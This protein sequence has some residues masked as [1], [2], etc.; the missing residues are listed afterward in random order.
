MDIFEFELRR[1]AYNGLSQKFNLGLKEEEII[2][3]VKKRPIKIQGKLQD[4]SPDQLKKKTLETYS[5]QKKS[6][7]KKS[8][9]QKIGKFSLADYINRLEYELFVI[10]KMGY[11]TYFLI[12]Q[13][14]INRAKKNKIAVGTGRWSAAGSLLSYLIWITDVDPMPY[15]LLF[16]R[17]L[18]PARV[19]MPD[20]DTDFEDELRDRVIDYV[21]EKYGEQKV[22][23]IGTYMKLAPR[24][25]FKDV[26]RIK[27]IKF[28]MANKISAMIEG[29]TLQQSVEE[30]PSLQE[31][32]EADP[33][34]K[35]IIDLASQLEWNIRQVWVHACWVIIS[36]KP[37]I[38]YTP[39]QYPPKGNKKE[40]VT[41]YDGH[42]LED[43]W[44]LKMDFLGLRNLSIIKN[45][46]K[47]IRAK[48]KE[49]NKQLPKLI[50]EFFDTMNFHPPLEDKKTFEIFQKWDTSGV[51][52]FESDWMKNWLKQLKPTNIDDIIAMVALYRP[53]PMAFIPSYID[54]KHW[55][56]KISYMSE[57]LKEILS[58][59]YSPEE[60][61]QEEKKLT[62]DLS[63]FMDITYWIPVYQEQLMRLVQAMAGFSLAEADLLRRWVGKKIKELIEKIKKDFV[64]KAQEYRNYKPETAD[65]IYEKMIMPAARYSF[66]K[67]HAA[68]YAL[69]AY[70]TAYLKA[71]Y[72]LEFHAALLRS[73][74][75]DT[76][77]LA[78]FINEL[79]IKWFNITPPSVNKSFAHMAAVWD[80]IV[81]WLNAIK[82]L[83]IEVANAIE[84]ERVKNWPYKSL[85]D[86][87]KRNKKIINK[88]LLEALTYSWALDEFVDRNLILKNLE[89]IL[90]WIK[91]INANEWSIG[92]F[93]AIDDH[94]LVLK[95]QNKITKEEKLLQEFNSFKTFVSSHPF[96]GLYKFLKWK[97][98]PI[99]TLY[100]EK[101]KGKVEIIGLVKEITP[102]R[103][104]GFFLTLEDVSWEIDIYLPDR[105]NINKFDV[106]VVK[107]T[108][109]TRLRPSQIIKIDLEEMI[110]Y[111]KK[112][113]KYDEKLK[114]SKV[115]K[116][117][118]NWT[119]SSKSQ[120][121]PIT[122]ISAPTNL[123]FKLPSDIE[124]LKQIKYITQTLQGDIEIKIEGIPFKVSPQGLKAIQDLLANK[125][126]N[127]TNNQSIV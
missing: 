73:V 10:H 24:A 17:F 92:L 68:C 45:T 74:E 26:A 75:E 95:P 80:Q 16:E 22:A 96:D 70:Q 34:I 49:E 64:K 102:F 90:N 2:N 87:L 9:G 38:N 20:I 14:Y 37:A 12:V 18:N 54:R 39:L 91:V 97:F 19:S 21:R 83:G 57:E 13:D 82:G 1:L 126:T 65:Y 3:L 93:G 120:S 76:D 100:D 84:E 110:N 113:G 62:E 41:Q 11:D 108:K 116:E 55:K 50:Q 60:V 72:P 104:K 115:R 40:Y 114:V 58:K 52:Q 117:R 69:I 35:E 66:N 15:D 4:L 23:R 42:V 99:S 30:S 6:F 47:I 46:L 59:K 53:G 112:A 56:E 123:E 8:E 61:I 5:D 119:S 32:I 105:L 107:W 86:F 7:I 101:T 85:E 78:K 67:S 111:A 124:I 25:A 43:I 121:Q 51:F 71:H 89:D 48:Y 109:N 118:A 44:L 36:P 27:G 28:D 31:L 77:K 33:K 94:P 29:K 63:P 98:L 103:R 125:K 81:L 79:Q 127:G 106:I 122:N 88:K